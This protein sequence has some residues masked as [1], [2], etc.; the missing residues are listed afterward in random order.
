MPEEVV[1]LQKGS[2]V[3]GKKA[4]FVTFLLLYFWVGSIIVHVRAR[5]EPLSAHFSLQEA[6]QVEQCDDEQASQP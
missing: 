1:Y 5:S 3:K 6:P 4:V 2:K